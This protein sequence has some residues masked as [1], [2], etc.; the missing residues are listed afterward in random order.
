MIA[1]CHHISRPQP[2]EDLAGK[3]ER[4]LCREGFRAHNF[5]IGNNHWQKRN[6]YPTEAGRQ[7]PAFLAAE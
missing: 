2:T 6:Q 1:P 7:Y 3:R 4:S 5:T